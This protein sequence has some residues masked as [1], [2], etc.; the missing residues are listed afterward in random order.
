M[1][2]PPQT[3][4]LSGSKWDAGCVVDSSP[5]RIVLEFY[6]RERLALE[7]YLR[8]VG[9]EVDACRDIVHEA[10]LKLYEH[11]LANGDA[12]NLRAWLYRVSHNL[13]MNGRHAA[14]TRRTEPLSEAVEPVSSAASPEKAILEREADLTLRNAMNELTPNQRR[15]LILRA[16][17]FKYRQIAEILQLST[18]AVAETVQRALG[19]LK[20]AV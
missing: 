11:L 5:Y 8:L 6:D 17:G 19:V 14:H 9:V 7:R 3:I 2:R 16:Q 15:C 4:A 12:T 1:T 10:F 13:A 18:S 20:K